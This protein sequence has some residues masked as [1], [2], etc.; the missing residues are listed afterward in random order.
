MYFEGT[1]YVDII[2]SLF[3]KKCFTVFNK[4]FKLMTFLV[5]IF[6]FVRGCQK[7]LRGKPQL[8]NIIVLIFTVF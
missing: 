3:K 2:I 8:L 6:Q 4:I 5:N 7:G 1:T